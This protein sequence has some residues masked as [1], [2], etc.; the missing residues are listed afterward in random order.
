MVRNQAFI[1]LGS[2]GK[3]TI[4][5]MNHLMLYMFRRAY[6]VVFG[7]FQASYYAFA[8][9]M[10]AKL[11]PPGFDSMVRLCLLLDPCQPYL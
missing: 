7:L 6:N 8:Q 2:S 9:T 1:R 10:M 5:L 11:S 3:L 4:V